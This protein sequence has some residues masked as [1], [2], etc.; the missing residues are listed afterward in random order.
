MRIIVPKSTIAQTESAPSGERVLALTTTGELYQPARLYFRVRDYKGVMRELNRLRCISADP[1]NQRMCWTYTDEARQPRTPYPYDEP[2]IPAGETLILGSL[3]IRDTRERMVL[4]VRS[5]E[6]ALNA[7]SFF[8]RRITR[9]T[10][11]ATH[12]TVV[13]RLFE[14]GGSLAGP[15]NLFS[16]ADLDTYEDPEVALD[17]LLEEVKGVHGVLK[18]AQALLLALESRSRR[19]LPMIE[20]LPV[21]SGANEIRQL[22]NALNIRQTIAMKHWQG[23]TDFTAF[24]LMQAVLKD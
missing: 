10:A 19:P 11:E 23:E 2:Q 24:D 18:R 16:D 6:R 20:T 12:L 4:D 1:T 7:V 17:Q 22:E 13:N 8:A 21:R 3:R 14:G 15:E 9:Q 5:F